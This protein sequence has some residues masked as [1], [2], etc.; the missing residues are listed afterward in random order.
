MKKIVLPLCITLIA[1]ALLIGGAFLLLL[2]M[3]GGGDIELPQN[4]QVDALQVVLLGEDTIAQALQAED[5]TA[6]A[7]AFDEILAQ[8]QSAGANAIALTGRVAASE[9]TGGTASEAIFRDS[10]ET[11]ATTAAVTAWDTWLTQADALQILITQASAAG[12]EVL[13]LPTDTDGTQLSADDLDSLPTYIT[14]LCEQ[15]NLRA[16]AP[17]GEASDVAATGTG[18]YLLLDSLDG[19]GGFDESNS[20]L[21]R[22]DTSPIALATA[23][24]ALATPQ[25]V[26]G[27]YSDIAADSEN[28]MLLAAYT[29]AGDVPDL[30][31]A[32]GS[33]SVAQ[34]L[35]V[36]YPITDGAS[37]STSTVFLMGT[38]DPDQP[39]TLD[40]EEIVRYGTRGVWGVLVSLSMG[41][42]SFTIAN[43]EETL[44]YTVKRISASSSSSSSSGG[45]VIS[46]ADGQRVRIT[47]DIT[48]AL[49]N[50]Y[51]SSTYQATL[52]MGAEV[53]VESYL[54]NAYGYAYAYRLTTGDY[55]YASSCTLISP[56]S[57]VYTSAT[58]GESDSGDTTI[59]LT[60]AQA[61][62]YR[63]WEGNTLTLTLLNVGID[64]DLPSADWFTAAAETDGENLIFTF[65]FTD[66]EPLYGWSVVYD[67]DADTTTLTF[68]KTP[69]LSDDATAP[70]SGV[71]VLLDAGHGL[72]DMGAMGSAGVDAPSE[73]DVNLALT[74][75]TKYRLEQLG[76]TVTLTRSDDSYPTLG[77]RVTMLNETAPDFFIS[78]HHNSVEL[79]S[80]VNTATGTE[81]YWFFE[82]GAA[83]GQS[84]VDAICDTTGRYNRGVFEGYYYVT[85]SNICPAVL[86]E[87]GFMTNPAEYEDI[88]SDETIW[89]EAGAIAQAI[90]DTVKANG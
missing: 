59:V 45:Q 56:E 69:H 43:G 70:L 38:S 88:E 4:V 62:I 5:E 50:A 1:F 7:A 14:A 29:T 36:T 46:T 48:S 35:A 67:N 9:A 66:D 33:M 51:S 21:L 68:K 24:D 64:T 16:I 60:G 72:D 30:F 17:I 39:L 34:S 15:Y 86:L 31:A 18:Q 74:L 71:V 23:L 3:R 65:T 19:S 13:L 37:I 41:S 2:F 57:P 61:G 28:A 54:T 77:D 25:Y 26:I 73:K 85:R 12:V 80:D 22:D 81:A 42:N 49:S 87:V 58:L 32:K 75:A 55:V 27:V 76:A 40:G 20:V 6:L 8:A 11:L 63:A 44:T 78:I 82:Q 79:T 90:Y 10:T 47:A 84:L 53:E 83:F 89:A 52:Y